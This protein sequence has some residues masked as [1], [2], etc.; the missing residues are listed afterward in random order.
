[1]PIRC[2]FKNP[3]NFSNFF[4]MAANIRSDNNAQLKAELHD[5]IQRHSCKVD[6]SQLERDRLEH[7]DRIAALMQQVAELTYKL[8][9]AQSTI[10]SLNIAAATL[11]STTRE[12]TSLRTQV[13]FLQSELDTSETTN[14]D[15]QRKLDREERMFADAYKE[16]QENKEECAQL[17]MKAVIA[18]Q[19]EKA[20]KKKMKA[21]C[22]MLKDDN[23]DVLS[24]RSSLRS[25]RRRTSVSI[26][27]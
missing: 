3:L 4:A 2:S 18:K 16:L 15:L 23:D 14:E 25:S 19:T 20:A 6:H 13:D 21:A 12:L 9:E 11:S 10:N 26:R 8:S 22:G 27:E 7:E 5:L 1:M 24:M 17:R